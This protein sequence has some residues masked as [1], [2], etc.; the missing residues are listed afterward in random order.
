MLVD[1]KAVFDQVDRKILLKNVWDKEIRGKMHEMIASIYKKTTNEVV[2]G[3][4][5]TEEFE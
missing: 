3:D 2:V 1:L 5:V 4:M